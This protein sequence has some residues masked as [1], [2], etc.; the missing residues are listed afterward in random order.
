MRLFRASALLTALALI[1]GC[2]QVRQ[3][4]RFFLTRCPEDGPNPEQGFDIVLQEVDLPGYLE[5]LR[6]ASRAFSVRTIAEVRDSDDSW[7]IYHVRQPGSAGAETL[8]IVAGVHGNEVAGAL[9]APD[10]LEDVRAHPEIYGG[11]DLHLIAPGNPV[12]VMHGARYNA[13][14]CDINRDFA[15]FETTEARAIR[16]VIGEAA[17]DLILSLH[18]GPHEGFFVI[19]TRSTPRSLATA[20]AAALESDG[21]ELATQSNLGTELSTPGVMEEGWFITGAKT[22]FRIRSLGAYA[23]RRSTPL[24]TTEGPWG[25]PDIEARVRGQVLAVRAAASELASGAPGE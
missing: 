2:T 21:V 18:E 23:H 10:I 19:A 25:E 12:G 22:L 5:A 13:Q 20:V 7:P 9:A 3:F 6:D 15:A 4:N 24:L 16:D 8:L 14:G 1:A 17:P 11:L